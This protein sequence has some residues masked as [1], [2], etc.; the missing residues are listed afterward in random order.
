MRRA[1]STSR[2]A[3]ATCYVYI[4]AASDGSLYTGVSGDP[5][6]RVSEHNA[7]KRGAKALRGKRPV[8]LLRRW[9]CRGRPEALRLEAEIKKLRA[10]DK[11]SMVLGNDSDRERG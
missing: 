7:G 6:R 2:G 5:D 10:A 4:A 11:L 8:R 3:R 9:R 1:D